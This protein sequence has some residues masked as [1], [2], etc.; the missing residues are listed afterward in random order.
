[1]PRTAVTRSWATPP[2]TDPDNLAVAMAI[3]AIGSGMSSRL[4]RTLERERHLVDG[5]AMND[6][7]LSRGSS[8]ALVS[9]HLKPGVSEEELT[10][11]VDEII[12]EFA[13]SGPREAELERARAQVERDWLESLAVVDERADLLNMHETLLGDANLVNTHLDRVRAITADQVTEAAN[14]WLSPEQASTV[15]HKEVA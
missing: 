10:G 11:A 14:R 2:I 13:A 1:M 3:D 12:A 5:I 4:I 6:F 7:G 9:A 15:V 8:A